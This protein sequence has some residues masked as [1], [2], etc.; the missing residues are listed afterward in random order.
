MKLLG[1]L[2][3]HLSKIKLKNLDSLEK[4][5]SN[6]FNEVKLKTIQNHVDYINGIIEEVISTKDSY[7]K[8]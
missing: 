7:S 5:I 6:F 1:L 2:K 3:N 8:Y 4:E